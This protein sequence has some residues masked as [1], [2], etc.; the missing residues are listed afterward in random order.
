MATIFFRADQIGFRTR[1]T[2]IGAA[3]NSTVKIDI[4]DLV[5]AGESS[6]GLGGTG[7]LGV[8][9]FRGITPRTCGVF[10]G[11]GKLAPLL[12]EPGDGTGGAGGGTTPG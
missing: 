1:R 12:N 7:A 11:I 9:G 10:A 4:Y 3:K 5:T 2:T 6:H 8:F